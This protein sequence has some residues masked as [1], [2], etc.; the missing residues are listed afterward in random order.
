MN[1][2]YRNGANA[3]WDLIRNIFIAGGDVRW[4]TR[5]EYRNGWVV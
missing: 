4:L 5:A 2:A 3:K 1:F